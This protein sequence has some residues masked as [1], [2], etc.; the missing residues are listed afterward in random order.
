MSI[1]LDQF[2]DK[3]DVYEHFEV[4]PNDWK[5][6]EVVLA[7]YGQ[8]S[9]EGTAYVLLFN[10]INGLF[11]EVNGGHCSCNGLEG[12][13]EPTEVTFE[14][15]NHRVTEGTFGTEGWG[16]EDRKNLYAEELKV[17]LHS[18]KYNKKFLEELTNVQKT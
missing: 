1:Y 8:E 2:T 12:Q 4:D 6:Y 3:E 9:Y 15:L 13:F 16:D 14:E 11:Y 18:I 5:N 7:Y 17:V 10:T